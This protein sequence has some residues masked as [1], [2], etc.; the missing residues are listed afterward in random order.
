MPNPHPATLQA[1]TPKKPIAGSVEW[2]EKIV[3]PALGYTAFREWQVALSQKVFEGG[4]VVCIAPTGSGKSALLHIPLMAAKLDKQRVLGISVAPTKTLCDDQARAADLRGLKAIAVHSDSLRAAAA[5]KRDLFKE[6]YDDKWDLFI[7]P[8]ELLHK[9]EV[10]DLFRAQMNPKSKLARINL[11]FIDECHLVREHG[12]LF[13]KTYATIG[14]VRPRLPHNIPWIAVTATLPS[15]DMTNSVLQSLGFGEGEYTMCR[16]RVD[17]PNIKYIPRFFRHPMSGS[18]IYDIAWII[19]PNVTTSSQIKKAII[20]CEKI[21]F[22][23]RVVDFLESLLPHDLLNRRTTVMPFHSLLSPEYRGVY[24]P[25]LR[26]G[27]TRILVGTDTLTYGLDVQDVETVVILGL[28]PSPERMTQEMG[29]AGRNGA[30]ARAFLFAPLW[31]REKPEDELKGTK[32]EAVERGRRQLMNRMLYQWFNGSI[33]ACPRN[34][35]CDYYGDSFIL[36][37]HCCII[38]EPEDGDFEDIK[39]WIKKLAQDIPKGTSG[40]AKPKLEHFELDKTLMYPAAQRILERWSIRT[41][42][43]I[44]GTDTIR[45]HTAFFPTHLRNKL[46]SRMHVV[47]NL[48]KLEALMNDWKYI[49]KCGPSLL[50]VCTKILDEFDEIWVERLQVVKRYHNDDGEEDDSQDKNESDDEEHESTQGQDVKR[51]RM[52]LSLSGKF[53]SNPALRMLT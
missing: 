29:R 50:K 8:P 24:V 14:Q 22:A 46:C 33:A 11:V 40:G 42:A 47:T 25:A 26:D 34:V 28:C 2:Y 13:R 39:K 38:H 20:F 32:Q 9:K 15:G 3:A 53:A 36:H 45:P 23:S 49:K 30:P 51:K 4:D 6:I 17:V 41:W 19:P 16:L 31:V 37:P 43:S 18:T 10:D 21:E 52:R 35:S 44:R 7:I 27:A 12:E 1:N 5:K 48:Q